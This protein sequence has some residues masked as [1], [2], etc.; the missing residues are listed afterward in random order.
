MKKLQCLKTILPLVVLGCMHAQAQEAGESEETAQKASKTGIR[1]VCSK[2]NGQAGNVFMKT[3]EKKVKKVELQTRFAGPRM[4]MPKDGAVVLLDKGFEIPEEVPNVVAQ[5]QIPPGCTKAVALLSPTEKSYSMQIFDE[6]TYKPGAVHLLNP[7]PL[8]LRL[9]IDNKPYVLKPKGVLHFTPDSAVAKN[10]PV[11]I[12]FEDPAAAKQVT[13]PQK[14]VDPWK[15]YTATTWRVHPDSAQ[16]GIFGWNGTTKR[17]ELNSV[18][19]YKEP[20]SAQAGE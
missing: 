10:Y 16:I 2:L 18:T 7:T 12:W 11:Q 4:P 17:P 6:Q 9:K 15:L 1:F 3:G 19:L 14:P 13:N 20:E 5:G 8:N